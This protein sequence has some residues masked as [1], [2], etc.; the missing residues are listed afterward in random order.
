MGAHCY[1]S[2]YVLLERFS[3]RELFQKRLSH[4]SGPGRFEGSS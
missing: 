2:T 1:L 4:N 3:P